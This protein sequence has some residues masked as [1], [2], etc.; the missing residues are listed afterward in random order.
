MADFRDLEAARKSD[1]DEGDLPTL[2]TDLN[3]YY[4]KI[5]TTGKGALI[6]DV[7]QFTNNPYGTIHKMR[8]PMAVLPLIY[9]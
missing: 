3:K 2:M 4:N 7:T 8:L 5:K 9:P 6:N 1:I